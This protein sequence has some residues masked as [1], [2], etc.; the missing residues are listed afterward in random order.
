MYTYIYICV[1]YIY[2]YIYV[3]IYIYTHTYIHTYRGLEL[4]LTRFLF[5][6]VEPADG[7]DYAEPLVSGSGKVALLQVR[8]R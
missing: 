1:I 2:I 7:R 3:Y 4:G 6:S 8:A 5:P